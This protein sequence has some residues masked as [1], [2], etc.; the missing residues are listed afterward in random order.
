MDMCLLFCCLPP[1]QKTKFNSRDLKLGNKHNCKL[2]AWRLLGSGYLLGGCKGLASSQS[3]IAFLGVQSSKALRNS[4]ASW[5]PGVLTLYTTQRVPSA[6]R[7]RRLFTGFRRLIPGLKMPLILVLHVLSLL[8]AQ[9][10]CVLCTWGNRDKRQ[11]LAVGCL[12]GWVMDNW[13]LDAMGPRRVGA[14]GAG[15]ILCWLSLLLRLWFSQRPPYGTGACSSVAFPPPPATIHFLPAARVVFKNVSVHATPISFETS[16]RLP[17]CFP[18]VWLLLPSAPHSPGPGFIP[19]WNVSHWLQF[20]GLCTGCGPRA[21]L[22]WLA[23]LGL[24]QFLRCRLHCHFSGVFPLYQFTRPSSC[25]LTLIFFT[26]PHTHLPLL[27]MSTLG[28]PGSHLPPSFC[29]CSGKVLGCMT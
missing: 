5:C 29:T 14:A 15:L 21:L 27:R 23:M 22:P 2:F 18:V 1:P 7:G 10:Y 3:Q 6:V 13:C 28:E 24:F 9:C 25:H 19:A 8:Q 20:W 16:S 17:T 26:F 12:Y 11:V 4:A